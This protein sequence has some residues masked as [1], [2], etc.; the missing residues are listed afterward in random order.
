[1]KQAELETEIDFLDGEKKTTRKKK[2]IK[3]KKD[4]KDES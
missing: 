4:I 3:R 2:K 1:L